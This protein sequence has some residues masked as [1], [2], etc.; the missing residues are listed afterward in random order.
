MNRDQLQA[1]ALKLDR[2][3]RARLA[4]V[5]LE[6]L[7]SLS[8]DECDQLWAEEALCRPLR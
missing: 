8:T 2:V 1:E 5:L 7:D 3:D 4:E 6:S